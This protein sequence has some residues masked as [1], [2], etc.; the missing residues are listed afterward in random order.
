MMG[1]NKRGSVNSGSEEGTRGDDEEAGMR[2]M[3][4]GEG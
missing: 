3:E 1:D 2:D 4:Y